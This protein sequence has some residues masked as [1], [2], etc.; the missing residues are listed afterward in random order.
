MNEVCMV[1][2]RLLD[3]RSEQ[4]PR[5]V[6]SRAGAF[7]WEIPVASRG[8]VEPGSCRR[9]PAEPGCPGCHVGKDP[10]PLP[11]S[12]SREQMDGKAHPTLWEG[13]KDLSIVPDAWL[14]PLPTVEWAGSS[15]TTVSQFLGVRTDKRVMEPATRHV[16]KWHRV[17]G[18]SKQCGMT[19]GQLCVLWA[20]LHPQMSLSPH[21]SDA[22]EWQL[23]YLPLSPVW[24]WNWNRVWMQDGNRQAKC[25]HVLSTSKCLPSASFCDI[26]EFWLN[27][28]NKWKL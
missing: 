18:C 15:K 19:S 6:S 25:C 14:L 24:R 2:W 11:H 16:W 20:A 9:L 17:K 27:K 7:I 21:Q 26:E 8:G 22:L 12:W 4:L 3:L 28:V 1:P 5:G 23:V 10:C 13:N